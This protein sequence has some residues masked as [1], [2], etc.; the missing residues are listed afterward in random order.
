M[1]DAGQGADGLVDVAGQGQVE[2][3][4]GAA[5]APG[6]AEP[7]GGHG[8]DDVGGEDRSAHATAG[9]DEVGPDHGLGQGV[10]GH[11][12][13]VVAGG[14]GLGPVGGGEDGDVGQAAGAQGGDGGPGVGAGAH[15]EGAAADQWRQMAGGLINADGDDAATLAGELGVVSNPAGGGRGSLDDSHEVGTECALGGG[16]L[17]GTADLADDLSLADHHGAQARGDGEHL[18]ASGRA[19]QVGQTQGPR[20]QARALGEEGCHGLAQAGRRGVGG[21]GAG[22]GAVRGGSAGV[23]AVDG[24]AGQRVEGR[25][26]PGVGPGV[27]VDQEGQT[28][29]GGQ[30]DDPAQRG[31]R[32]QE[33]RAQPR[34]DRPQP[35]DD[36]EARQSVVGGEKMSSHSE[37]Y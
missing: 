28:V 29:A 20:S 5:G 16:G 17:G 3:D 30:D 1:D 27:G 13:Q 8:G 33:V 34:G 26:A 31:D 18:A 6:R 10:R 2:D 35:G 12:A 32:L 7:L 23:R 37:R 11:G 4:Q 25:R 15:D 21:R 22:G 14:E 36:V 19:G 9:D 24:G